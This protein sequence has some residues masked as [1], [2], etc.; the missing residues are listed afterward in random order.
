MANNPKY[1]KRFLAR[2]LE[3]RR[4]RFI[5]IHSTKCQSLS[6]QPLKTINK[7]FNLGKLKRETLQYQNMENIPYHY[8]FDKIDEDYEGIIGAPLNVRLDFPDQDELFNRAI[9]IGILF[10]FDVT[11]MDDRGYD[12]LAFKIVNPLAYW[13]SIPKG[14]IYMHTDTMIN[15]NYNCPG[16]FFDIAKFRGYI[17]KYW[18]TSIR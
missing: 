18:R 13:F 17:Q 5:I 7:Q 9:H 3:T 15:K 16:T 1:P 10:D 12:A 11:T 2:P 14:N 8:L 6:V 4:P